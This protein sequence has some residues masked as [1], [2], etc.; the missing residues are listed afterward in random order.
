MSEAYL[1]HAQ[2]WF[3]PITAE[4]SK[5]QKGAKS[6]LIIGVNGSQGSG[7]ST[8]ASY[9]SMIFESEYNLKCVVMSLDD[10]YFTQDKRNELAQQVH[11]LLATRGVPGTHDTQLLQR[12]MSN[13]KSSLHTTIPRFNKAIDNP[14][15]ISEW[16]DITP[17]VDIIIVEGWCWGVRAQGA[18]DITCPANSL[19]VQQDANAVWR[20]YVNDQL[21]TAY[22]PLYELVDIWLM[23]KAPAFSTVMQ[24]RFE[25]EQ[26]LAAR[27]QQTGGDSSKVMTQEQISEFISY[28]Q[29][30][31][32]HG[33]QQL[34]NHC[35]YVWDLRSDRRIQSLHR[36]KEYLI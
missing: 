32:E 36:P 30:L 15:P 25:Q 34:P 9:L 14:F 31:T 4:I 19:E 21:K 23:L 3:K 6:P 27:V 7:K 20:N 24:W 17:P 2:H 12:V 16:T 8:L 28:F 29:R 11:P 18:N 33:L 13:L 1:E 26:K 35:H 10:F 22:E 5:H